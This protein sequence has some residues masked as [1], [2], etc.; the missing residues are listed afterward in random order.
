MRVSRDGGGLLGWASVWAV[1]EIRVEANG[2]LQVRCWIAVRNAVDPTQN[3][4][5]RIN[6][7]SKVSSK[8]K[9]HE[10]IDS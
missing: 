4:T 9:H 1:S 7:E 10:N 3:S 8:Q 5:S 2:G 6:W